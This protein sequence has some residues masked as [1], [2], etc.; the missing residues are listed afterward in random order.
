MWSKVFYPKGIPAQPSAAVNRTYPTSV[1]LVY[2]ICKQS[3]AAR[4]LLI[5]L[6]ADRTIRD[7]HVGALSEMLVDG[8]LDFTETTA[9]TKGIQGD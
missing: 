7:T 6:Q 2:E 8:R 4:S 9:F 5:P 3:L 1:D